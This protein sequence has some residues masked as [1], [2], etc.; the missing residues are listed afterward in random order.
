MSSSLEVL[1]AIQDELQQGGFTLIEDERVILDTLRR[2][3]VR[4]ENVRLNTGTDRYAFNALQ[5]NFLPEEYKP[6]AGSY[7]KLAESRT[8]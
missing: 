2:H 1:V 6:P 3:G 7:G 4:R 5:M 8:T